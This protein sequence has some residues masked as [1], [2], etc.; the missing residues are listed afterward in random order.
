MEIVC[1]G[2]SL[3]DYDHE[4]W[5]IGREYNSRYINDIEI[6]LKNWINFSPSIDPTCWHYAK[7]L[8]SPFAGE[9]VSPTDAEGSVSSLDQYLSFN[10]DEGFIDGHKICTSWNLFHKQGCQYEY[11]NPG[12]ICQYIHHCSICQANCINYMPHKAWQCSD[13]DSFSNYD[14]ETLI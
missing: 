12:K 2:S 9:Y 1:L 14:P 11:L 7:E 5:K 13:M 6:G 8:V 3:D 10:S 4:S